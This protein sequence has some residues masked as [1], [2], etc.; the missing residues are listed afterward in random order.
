MIFPQGLTKNIWLLSWATFLNRTTGFLALFAAMFFSSVGFEQ[1]RIVLA[2]FL[3]G[4]AGVL[5]STIA[6]SI[7][8]A[9]GSKKV[10]IGTTALNVPLALG[11]AFAESPP[12]I[13]ALSV[14]SVFLSQAFIPPASGIGYRARQSVNVRFLSNIHQCR[15]HYCTSYRGNYRDRTFLHFIPH[16]CSRISTHSI[17]PFLLPLRPS[18]NSSR[19]WGRIFSTP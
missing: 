10:L 9:I 3:C 18:I 19:I 8:D 6:G 11:L 5:S 13:I 2:L 14:A 1:E 7:A 16:F 4:T 12:L 15:K 17:Y